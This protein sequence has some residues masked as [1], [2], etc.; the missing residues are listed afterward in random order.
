M[1]REGL[2]CALCDCVAIALV[3]LASIVV[4]PL[5]YLVGLD[6]VDGSVIA[7]LVIAL[8]VLATLLLLFVLKIMKVYKFVGVKVYSRSEK[9]LEEDDAALVT[10]P[11]NLV[12]DEQK[13]EYCQ[14]QI[15]YLRST[16]LDIGRDDSSHGS[17]Y[18]SQGGSRGSGH[19]DASDK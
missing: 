4:F 9:S 13:F 19:S 3:Y 8:V 10:F 16:L 14:T 5:L 17:S 15:R 11:V 1:C 12:D 2:I 18:N 6:P 7:S